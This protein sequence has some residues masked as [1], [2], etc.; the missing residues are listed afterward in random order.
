MFVSSL[1]D[2]VISDETTVFFKWQYD[3]DLKK[4]KKKLK[5]NSDNLQEQQKEY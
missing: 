4:K 3:G 1:T 5:R 2:K